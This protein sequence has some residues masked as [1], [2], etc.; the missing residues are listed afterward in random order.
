MTVRSDQHFNRNLL[1]AVEVY[2]TGPYPNG[3][4]HD[5]FE[6][7]VLPLDYQYNP[8]RLKFPF[9]QLVKPRFFDPANYYWQDRKRHNRCFFKRHQI[10][11]ACANG[12]DSESVSYLFELWFNKLQLEYNR[13]ILPIVYD[14]GYVI[15]FLRELLG[16]ETYGY[17]FHPY[18]RDILSTSLM[19]N[20]RANHFC[21]NFP[22]QKNVL[23][24]LAS[25]LGIQLIQQ[26]DILM[27]TQLIAQSYKRLVEFT[28]GL[29][30]MQASRSVVPVESPSNVQET[31]PDEPQDLENIRGT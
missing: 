8:S 17:I 23:T 30:D 6:I 18:V 12:I 19:F 22:F 7:C 13:K 10:E 3:M 11:N 31:V 1:C 28:T 4:E 5:V 9:Q 14:A 26:T 24:Y 27:R 21:E 29:A 15:P 16:I 2:A 20:D 25:H